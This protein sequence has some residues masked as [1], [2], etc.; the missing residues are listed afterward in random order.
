[1]VALDRIAAA[2]DARLAVTADERADDATGVWRSAA[3]RVQRLG[4]ALEPDAVPPAW[5]CGESGAMDALLLHRPWGVDD[6]SLPE[7][8]GVLACHR[9]FDAALTTATTRRSLVHSAW[10]KSSR[11]RKKTAARWAWSARS[12]RL[13]PLMRRCA[14]SWRSW[15]D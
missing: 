13:S 7:G 3:G 9:P 5:L 4:L 2:L 10:A 15:G 1:M 14:G 8:A 11:L 12:P 6:L